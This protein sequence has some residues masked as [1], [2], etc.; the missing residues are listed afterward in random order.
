MGT[1]AVVG[2]G[3]AGAVTAVRLLERASGRLEV[4]LIDPVPGH[5][6]G[7]AYATADPRHRLNTPAG[8]MSASADDPLDFVRWLGGQAGPGDYVPRAQFGAYL[9]DFLDRTV[10]RGGSASLRRI[11]ARVVGLRAGR[12][13]ASVRLAH[14]GAIE[15]DAVVLAIGS[16]PA[17]T[18]GIAERLRESARFVADPWAPGAVAAVRETGDVLLV[19]TGL[20]MIDMALSLERPG[21]VVHAVSRHGLLPRAHSNTPAEPVDPP[22]FAGLVG[23]SSVRRAVLRHVGARV[24]ADGDWRAA[25]DALRPLVPTLWAG[26]PIADRLR[27]LTQDRRLWDVH[28]HRMPAT[29]AAEVDALRVSGRLVVHAGEITDAARVADGLRVTLSDG[30]SLRVAAVVNCTGV[31][32]YV[33]RV[34]DPLVDELVATGG[35]RPGPLG[36]GFD[37]A[38]DGRIL[39][40]DG[41]RVPVWTLG[42]PRRGTLWETT[43]FPE[44]RKQARDIAASVLAAGQQPITDS[45]EFEPWRHPD[46]T[47]DGRRR[48]HPLWTAGSPS[49]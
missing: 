27:F 12:T 36:L 24:R 9:A 10:N 40:A 30:A 29:T 41:R 2:A 43:A 49:G 48:Q 13:G 6:R 17:S 4:L 44:I 32:E 47:R 42:S 21:R 35:A 31:H 46:R 34:S 39:P 14:G 19:G 7:V 8:Q 33:G 23:L 11:H 25:I 45:E 37:T 26:M 38:P 16:F 28:R 18:M 3:A 15:A 22:D 1:V 20:T 5:G